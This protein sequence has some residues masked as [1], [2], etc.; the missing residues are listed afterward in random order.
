MSGCAPQVSGLRKARAANVQRS[1]A[2][3]RQKDSAVRDATG[4]SRILL[5]ATIIPLKVLP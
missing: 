4:D 5:T 3:M 2:Q 1:T